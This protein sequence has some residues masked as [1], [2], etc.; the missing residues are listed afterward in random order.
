MEKGK[1]YEAIR[2]VLA[3]T[4]HMLARAEIMSG[5]TMAEIN[6]LLDKNGIATG[7][8]TAA[9]MYATW[10]CYVL[11]KMNGD[12]LCSEIDALVDEAEKNGS[13]IQAFLA[14]VRETLARHDTQ[15]GSL[16][17]SCTVKE[18]MD[19]YSMLDR[20]LGTKYPGP[21]GADV[22]VRVLMKEYAFRPDTDFVAGVLRGIWECS[23]RLLSDTERSQFRRL[24]KGVRDKAIVPVHA[25]ILETAQAFGLKDA[26]EL[27][28]NHDQD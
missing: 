19:W 20:I 1:Q 17:V 28:G 11:S 23:Y 3:Y 26:E 9:E 5:R 13:S 8:T 24:L 16:A 4:P 18:N 2:E 25:V 22:L 7:T 27:E 21:S 12:K 14:S 6:G 15:I 10:A